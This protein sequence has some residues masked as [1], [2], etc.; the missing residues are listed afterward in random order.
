[1]T[2]AWMFLYLGGLVHLLALNGFSNQRGALPLIFLPVAA[3]ALLPWAQRRFGGLFGPVPTALLALAGLGSSLVLGRLLLL[4]GWETHALLPDALVALAGLGALWAAASDARA[5]GPGDWAWVGLWLLAGFMDPVLPLVGAG[6][7]AALQ[8]FGRWPGSACT[9]ARGLRRPFLAFL[10]LGLAVP[11]AWW[12][13]GL[14]P[15]WA[16]ASGALGLGASLACLGPLR[17][18]L[19]GLPEG[20]LLWGAGLLAILYHPRLGPAWGLVLGSVAGGLEARRRGALATASLA[21]LLGLVLSFALHANAWLPG[22]RHLI[23]LG[24]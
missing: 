7:A 11:K 12:D 23:W 17:R 13:F 14:Q 5:S 4:G 3:C 20:V 19:A 8:A 15:E 1:M 18:R 9:E 22:L 6:L 21:F 16:F 2:A 10:L 24:N